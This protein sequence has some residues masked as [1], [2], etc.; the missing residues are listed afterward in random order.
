MCGR[1]V[2]YSDPEVY[3]LAFGLDSLAPRSPRFNL[4]P[5]QPLFAIR[6]GP[7][8]RE[9]FTPTWGL[10]PSWSQGPDSRFSMINARSETVHLRPAYRALFRT[11]RCL[12]PSEGFYEWQVQGQQ[13]QPYLIGL[14]DG[15]PFA[16]AGLWDAWQD[17]AGGILLSC[18]IVVTEANPLVARIHDRMPLIL[19]PETHAQWLDPQER[20]QARL[21]S[22]LR[23]YPEA[24]MSLRP[25]SRRV[26]DARLDQ[27]DLIEA[28]VED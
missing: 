27:P 7:A 26:N 28:L 5:G 15:A 16:M 22:L 1:F 23:P 20:S 3:A 4:A 6:S 12:V 11:R 24:A 19:P 18:S 9:G 21:R 13:R 17:P 14:Q 25:V 8:G 2:Q 10:V